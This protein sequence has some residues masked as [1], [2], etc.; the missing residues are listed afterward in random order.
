MNKEKTCYQF[1]ILL[2]REFK[3]RSAYKCSW[4]YMNNNLWSRILS[5][6]TDENISCKLMKPSGPLPKIKLPLFYN[7]DYVDAV[8]ICETWICVKYRQLGPRIG[9]IRLPPW[10]IS[11]KKKKIFQDE[12]LRVDWNKNQDSSMVE[13]Q[14]RDQEVRVRIPVLVQIFLLKF[15]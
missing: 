13:R 2:K 1:F 7:F 10:N 6:D 8:L 4:E 14:N 5:C 3:L 9:K 12:S 15:M 11:E